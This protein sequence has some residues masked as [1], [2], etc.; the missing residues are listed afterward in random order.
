LIAKAWLKV[1]ASLVEAYLRA[2]AKTA[3]I[4]FCLDNG[5]DFMPRA[6]I[7]AVS[8][9]LLASAPLLLPFWNAHSLLLI[10]AYLGSAPLTLTA[11]QFEAVV[12]DSIGGQL[13]QLIFDRIGLSVR[14]LSIRSPEGR[15]IDM[16]EM[17]E[18]KPSL[19]M[20]A[21][22][23]GP[24]RAVSTGMARLARHYAGC[25][26]P[27]SLA[28]DRAVFIFP[29]I[30]MLVPLPGATILLALGSRLGTRGAVA[31]TRLSLQSAL[32]DL[33]AKSAGALRTSRI[34]LRCSKK[35]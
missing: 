7:A 18:Q 3:E 22:S 34:Q 10:S 12:D 25:V 19:V 14:R 20:A 21:D 33:E 26:R 27:V 29:K 24:Y 11:Q 35:I 4:R 16:R 1:A 32:L 9:E 5:V 13:T 8:S 30:R 23:H 15:L 2:V 28:C 17:L 31:D 6:E